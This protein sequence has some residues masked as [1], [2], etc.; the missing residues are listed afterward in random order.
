MK[1]STSF[2][3]G[4][5]L[6][7]S[8]D[9]GIVTFAPDLRDSERWF[10]WAFEVTGAQG[11]TVTFQMG[12]RY[13]GYHG[14]AIS[15]DLKTWE[16]THTASQDLTSFTY[17][18]GMDE[19]RVYF[20]HHMLYLPHHLEDFV[21]RNGVEITTCAM[22]RHGSPIPRIEVGEGAHTILLTARHHACEGA[23]SYVLEGFVEE[24]LRHPLANHRLVIFP[25]VDTDGVYTGDQGKGRH[26]HDHNSDYIDTPIYPGVAA[27]KEAL[28]Q[29][30]PVAVFDFHSPWHNTGRND[31]VFIVQKPRLLSHMERYARH[32]EGAITPDALPYRTSNDIAPYED[33]NKCVG[34]TALST[35]SLHTLE[36]VDLVITVE[37][38]YFGTKDCPANVEN[39]R[40][41]GNC[42]WQGYLNY[43]KESE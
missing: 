16:W 14:A 29:L 22:D 40:H 24:Y 31:T 39:L 27:V 37:N 11:K 10:Y 15:H 17:T 5:A 23:G 42:M 36:D 34:H 26:P 35:Y 32:F 43:R 19:E 30:S 7:L 8:C 20:A 1:L 12:N 21:R 2:P 28:H 13:I 41:T 18:F 33:W 3:G 9:T 4:N 25:F 38:T 6:F